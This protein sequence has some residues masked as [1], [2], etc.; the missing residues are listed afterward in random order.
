MK[1][2]SVVTTKT[3]SWFVMTVADLITL[4]ALGSMLSLS[5]TAGTA[6]DV[7]RGT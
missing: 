4:T 3:S 5:K 6:L 2:A 1:F 7:P